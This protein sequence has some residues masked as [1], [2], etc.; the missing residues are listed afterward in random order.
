MKEHE[1]I[2]EDLRDYLKGKGVKTETY[3]CTPW[4][5]KPQWHLSFTMHPGFHHAIVNNA[6]R[7]PLGWHEQF[8][9]KP[10]VYLADP[11]Y[12]EKFYQYLK[13]KNIK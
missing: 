8:S 6:I 11:E 10:V 4:K 5:A 1:V 7:G 3:F 13:K 2:L 12:K 9:T